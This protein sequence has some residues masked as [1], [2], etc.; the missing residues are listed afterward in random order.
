MCIFL[1]EKCRNVFGSC[2]QLQQAPGR[3]DPGAFHLLPFPARK[4]PQKTLTNPCPSG[5]IYR[6]SVRLRIEYG[7]VPEWPMGTDCKSA[8][9]SFGGSN[10][11]APTKKTSVENTLVF[12]FIR[13]LKFHPQGWIRTAAATSLKT[14]QKQPSATATTTAS[15]RSREELLGLRPAGCTC[16]PRHD[17]AAGSRDPGSFLFCAARDIHPRP[18]KNLNVSRCIPLFLFHLSLKAALPCRVT[19]KTPCDLSRSVFAFDA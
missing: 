13:Y 18:P 3:F 4:F 8:A 16:R 10:P 1:S 17:V 15:G 7:R 19:K 14:A 11:P 12:C 2:H 5:N 9:F 6:Q